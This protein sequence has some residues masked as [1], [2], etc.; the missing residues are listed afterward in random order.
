[1]KR[2]N[3]LSSINPT[4]IKVEK[5]E[6]T[7]TQ[8]RK[9]R[10][11]AFIEVLRDTFDSQATFHQN[12][13]I[14]NGEAG[15]LSS[16]RWSSSCVELDEEGL[17]LTLNKAMYHRRLGSL[18]MNFFIATPLESTFIGG[19]INLSTSFVEC[20]KYQALIRPPRVP[21]IVTSF[22]L[23]G[24]GS[25]EITAVEFVGNS[26]NTVQIGH[27]SP[28]Y[29]AYHTVEVVPREDGW[30]QVLL[31][32][33]EG[34]IEWTIND[35]RIHS[36]KERVPKIPLKP[37]FCIWSVDSGI[38]QAVLWAGR[39]TYHGTPVYAYVKQFNIT[40]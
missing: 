1:M 26:T 16:C 24:S 28:E 27:C 37:C 18:L 19:R 8:R 38:E 7:P 10:S 2:W 34:S 4:A 29:E 6:T 14:S 15:I 11:N 30:F 20:G 33:N 35:H 13:R 36:T 21:G 25:N 12:W 17:R 31:V 32:W 39:H 23:K 40:V 9:Q 3:R 5:D 22:L